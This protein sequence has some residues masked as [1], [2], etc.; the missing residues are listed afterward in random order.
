[1]FLCAGGTCSTDSISAECVIQSSSIKVVSLPCVAKVW[2]GAGALGSLS[3]WILLWSVP[4]MHV[5]GFL[6]LLVEEEQCAKLPPQ[7]FY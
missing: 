1:M 2:G 4:G 5:F 6:L 3:A 7:P